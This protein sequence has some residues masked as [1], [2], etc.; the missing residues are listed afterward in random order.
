[1]GST[2]A[3]V[4]RPAELGCTGSEL[5][6]SSRAGLNFSPDTSSVSDVAEFLQ[7][8]LQDNCGLTLRPAVGAAAFAAVPGIT[9][10]LTDD[11]SLR[12]EGAYRLKV[13]DNGASLL[14]GTPAGLFYGVQSLV[15]LL[16]ADA[17]RNGE[18]LL[19]GV[20]ITDQPR[21]RWRG[22][23]L[24]VSR[25][26]FPIAF[27]KKYIDLLARHKMNVFHWHLTDDQGWRVEIKRFPRL[28]EVGAWRRSADG[29][30]YGGFYTQ[31]EIREVVEYARRRFVTIVPEIEMPGH[32]SAALAAYPEYSCTSGPFDVP[33]QWG[34]FDD[35]YC[36]GKDAT[37]AF[38]EGILSETA[39]LFPGQLIHIGGDEC[40]KT[41]WHAHDLCRNR[42][43]NEGLGTVDE[44]QAHF[45]SRIARHLELLGKCLIGW[46]E[47]LD[48]GAPPGATV[49]AWRDLRKGIEAACTGHDVVMT[50]MSH[51]YFDHY[52]G[53]AGE[54]KAIGGFTP[55]S[56]VYN[57][58]PVPE[59][60][61]PE[62]TGR[63]LGAQGNVW[64]EYMP[65]SR[66]V[67]YMVFPRLCALSE[68][69][70]SP[71]ESRSW[72][73]FLSRLRLHLKRLDKLGVNY[74]RLTD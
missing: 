16:P 47:I 5:Q 45:L 48:G 20:E 22:M 50:P 55:L 65:D 27:I 25:H 46:D 49:M 36:P 12:S 57:F 17:G 28:T 41:R 32:A 31:P 23:H 19:P 68:V 29:Q 73:D 69:L 14:A 11:E 59:E 24:D 34:V 43:K 66:H 63:V 30:V 26:F 54:P 44:L 35:V 56:A 74:R 2:I 51:C 8:E 1:M 70:W 21:F 58:D 18:V 60:L 37:F 72:P 40:P 52:Q 9:I 67:E 71:R 64:T 42:M 39:D 61:S 3:V 15:Q 7:A 33:V 10:A 38:L 6:L 53:P 62:L 4:P 13:N